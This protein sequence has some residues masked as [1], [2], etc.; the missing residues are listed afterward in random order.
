MD[1]PPPF[2]DREATDILLEEL[3]FRFHPHGYLEPGQEKKFTALQELIASAVAAWSD[4]RPEG[5][6]ETWE[7]YNNE[8]QEWAQEYLVG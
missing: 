2:L 4:A 3:G 8:L 5:D 6:E 7:S 1:Y